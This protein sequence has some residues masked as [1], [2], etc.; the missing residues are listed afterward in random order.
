VGLA[1]VVR[2]AIGKVIAMKIAMSRWN[3]AVNARAQQL[4]EGLDRLLAGL[5][6]VGAAGVEHVVSE[7][8]E[9]RHRPLRF[10]GRQVFQHLDAHYQVVAP[11]ERLQD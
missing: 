8:H 7:P 5:G 2:K 10:A 3:C 1:V 4:A 9:V 6:Q 11:R